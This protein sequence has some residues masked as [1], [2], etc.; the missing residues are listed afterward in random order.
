LVPVL[1]WL[2]KG[3]SLYLRRTKGVTWWIFFMHK[4]LM[5]LMGR[6]YVVSFYGVS[7]TT[8]DYHN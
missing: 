5:V 6:Y 4:K 2:L 7:F 3:L 1:I 8:V